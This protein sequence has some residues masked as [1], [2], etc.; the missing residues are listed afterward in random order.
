MNA[1][2][3][4]WD[5]RTV[6][7]VLNACA[8]T[9]DTE[10]AE[11]IRARAEAGGIE[12]NEFMIS[13]LMRAYTAQRFGTTKEKKMKNVLRLLEDSRR[14][15]K[16]EE[17]VPPIVFDSYV[18]CLVLLNENEEALRVYNDREKEARGDLTLWRWR[19]H[20]RRRQRRLDSAQSVAWLPAP[21]VMRV[22]LSPG[23]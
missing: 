17:K 19:W 7:S 12:I 16:G 2:G 13:A 15:C 1:R 4:Q 23:S 20:W 11:D 6:T 9:G 8:A 14:L 18:A 10:M 5:H 22:S 21:V 3:V